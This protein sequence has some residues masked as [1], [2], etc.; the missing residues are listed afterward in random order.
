M[1]NVFLTSLTTPEVRQLFRQELEIFF[2]KHNQSPVSKEEIQ[3]FTISELAAYLKCTKATIH[4]YKKRG[5]FKYY[6]TGR[7]VY[8]KKSEVDKALEVGNKKG[9]KNG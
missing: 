9:L 8:F 1:E 3:Q 5:I 2:E 7:T 6:Q 4:A